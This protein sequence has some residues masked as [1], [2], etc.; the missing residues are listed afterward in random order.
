MLTFLA[1]RKGSSRYHGTMFGIPLATSLIERQPHIR[2]S[3]MILDKRFSNARITFTLITVMFGSVFGQAQTPTATWLGRYVEEVEWDDGGLLWKIQKRSSEE[4]FSPRSQYS[5][6]SSVRYFYDRATALRYGMSWTETKTTYRKNGT[7]FSEFR[8]SANGYRRQENYALHS[9][10]APDCIGRDRYFPGSQ[11]RITA[12]YHP[13]L[14]VSASGRQQGTRKWDVSIT[15]TD[16]NTSR[17]VSCPLQVVELRP[18]YYILKTPCRLASLAC[19]L[20]A[21]IYPH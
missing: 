17:R 5:A 2:Q 8:D 16:W 4:L 1:Y 18:S 12:D 10:S 19:S 20:S 15:G 21:S 6:T 3:S 9:A 7:C 14:K 11:M 13:K